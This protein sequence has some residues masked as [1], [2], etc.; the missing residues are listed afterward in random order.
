[1]HEKIAA[2]LRGNLFLPAAV[3]ALLL[4]VGSELDRLRA[5][6]NDLRSKIEKE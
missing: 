2:I 3:K 6:V 5:E 4:E 1:M